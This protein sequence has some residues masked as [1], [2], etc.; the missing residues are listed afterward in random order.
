MISYSEM[1]LSTWYWFGVIPIEIFEIIDS[2]G[3]LLRKMLERRLDL[4]ASIQD[5]VIPIL[6]T[7][8]QTL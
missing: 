8:A 4:W 2:M 1:W 3:R 6:A 5:W 7:G